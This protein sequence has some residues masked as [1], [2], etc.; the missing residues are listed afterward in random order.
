MPRLQHT[1]LPEGYELR[2]IVL[3]GRELAFTLRRSA[4]R[5]LGMTIDRRGLVV[6]IP[7]RV[8]L[9]ETERFMFERADWILARLSE[10]AARPE[11]LKPSVG[12]G[13]RL[14]VL[15]EPC[16]VVCLAGSNRARWVEGMGLRELHLHLRRTEDTEALL[17][18]G[19]QQYALQYFTGRVEEYVFR[20]NQIVQGIASPQVR[21]SNARTRWGSCSRLSG[22]RLNWRLIH[23]PRPQIDYVVAHEV[24]HLIEM[25]HSPRFW[26]L[27]QRLQPDYEVQQA[28]L[29][30]A[31]QIIPAL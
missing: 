1:E 19:L 8:S 30:R 2:Q 16:T 10:W 15:G 11:P 24:A 22:I 31:S 13:M 18:R 27:V 29:K 12:D 6:T 26:Q 23:L 4:R 17:L 20:L 3:Q 7:S 28:A 25:N 14:P 21:L 5:T 9:R